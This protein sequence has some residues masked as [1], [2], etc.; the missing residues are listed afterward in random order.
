LCETWEVLGFTPPIPAG[1]SPTSAQA[2]GEGRDGARRPNT[3]R[4]TASSARSLPG[5]G[6]GED[7]EPKAPDS[8]RTCSGPYAQAQWA[9]REA[10]SPTDTVWPPPF[11]DAEP[12]VADVME[13]VPEEL[14]ST[15]AAPEPLAIAAVVSSQKSSGCSS[16]TQATENISARSSSDLWLYAAR[17]ANGVDVAVE[18]QQSTAKKVPHRHTQLDKQ[19]PNLASGAR[20]ASPRTPSATK[21][22]ESEEEC[23][24]VDE[25]FARRRHSTATD[26]VRLPD[27]AG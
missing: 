12:G 23:E 26:V 11:F 9:A 2:C 19:N 16:R 15:P 24:G 5:W 8:M 18:D 4:S 17:V 10:A 20:L 7:C 6:L 14:P 1:V 21:P 25:C 13:P 3:G 27:A 22:H